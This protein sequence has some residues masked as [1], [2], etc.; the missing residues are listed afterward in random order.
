MLTNAALKRTLL[1]APEIL[2]ST[3]ARFR[4]KKGATTMRLAFFAASIIQIL[5]LKGKNI[6]VFIASSRIVGFE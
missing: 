1:C 5:D 6:F 3:G 4:Y 2:P